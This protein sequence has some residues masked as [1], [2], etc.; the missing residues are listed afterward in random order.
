[1]AWGSRSTRGQA[2]QC[3]GA[4][5]WAGLGTMRPSI[6]ARPVGHGCS[7]RGAML[8]GTT[9]PFLVRPKNYFF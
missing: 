1:M 5:G 2:T 4:V 8:G 9:G 7:G 3:M 6:A